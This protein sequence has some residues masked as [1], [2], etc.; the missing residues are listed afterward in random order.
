MPFHRPG[1]EKSVLESVIYEIIML[2][3]WSS[4]TDSILVDEP[5]KGHVRTW[6]HAY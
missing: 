1:I 6:I 3:N 5:V 2:I 4:G